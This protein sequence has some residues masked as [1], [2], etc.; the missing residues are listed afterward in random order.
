MEFNNNKVNNMGQTQQQQ[1]QP[2]PYPQ[3]QP[4][5]YQNAQPQMGQP[6][7]QQ[8]GQPGMQQMGQPMQQAPGQQQMSQM[9][10]LR[11]QMMQQG[12]QQQQP[13]ATTMQQGG[14]YNP[15]GMQQ[16]AQ[17]TQPQPQQQAQQNVPLRQQMKQ[18][19]QQPT[20]IPEFEEADSGKEKSKM[21]PKTILIGVGLVIVTLIILFVFSQLNKADQKPQQESG[22]VDEF[23]N[24]V[25]DDPF[26]N[27][28]LIFIE[29]NDDIVGYEFDQIAELRAAGYTGDE[30]EEN[31]ANGV[32][33]EDLI[34][35]AEDARQAWIDEAIKPL[36]DTAS[37]EYKNSVRNTWLGL[38]E[39]Y[40]VEDFSQTGSY[41]EDTKNFDYEKIEARGFQLYVKIF[42]DDTNHDDYFFLAVEPSQYLQLKDQG[43]V[44]VTYRY[45]VPII[46]SEEDQVFLEDTSRM[47]I[48]DA[49]LTIYN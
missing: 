1:G 31:E 37:D 33:F 3:G 40:D 26:A 39:R 30:I 49:S 4:G 12:A 9:D 6:G 46:W 24:P 42:L 28:D 45:T 19:N 7:M 15:A 25:S 11:Q 41:Y 20:E 38:P 16:Q 27:D 29:P 10:R 8:M 23:G 17:Q 48:V 35:Q 13:Q 2:M 32:P 22:S 47:F 44:I 43:N 36:Y 5:Y 34:K 14:T 18:Q 21:S